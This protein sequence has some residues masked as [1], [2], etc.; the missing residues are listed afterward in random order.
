LGG[1][2]FGGRTYA[3]DQNNTIDKSFLLKVYR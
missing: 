3:P 1:K 2:G